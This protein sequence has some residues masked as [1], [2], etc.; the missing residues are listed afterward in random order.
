MSFHTPEY[1]GFTIVEIMICFVII[2]V[3]AAIVI[4]TYRDS[5]MRARDARRASDMQQ[6]RQ[7]TLL[8]SVNEGALPRT[9]VYTEDN[10]GG[11]DTSAIG[12]WL[13]F[14]SKVSSTVPPKDP[15]NNEMGD[16]TALTAKYTY[17]YYCYHPAWDF[18]SPDP[19]HDIARFGYRTELTNELKYTDVP[20]SSCLGSWP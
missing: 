16:P 10:A 17:F 3:L 15:I 8:Y 11:Y 14:L 18:W 5:Q 7:L 4:V 6:L 20:V 2:G 13:P 12:S 19:D 1:K 9:M